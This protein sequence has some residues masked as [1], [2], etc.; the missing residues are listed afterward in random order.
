VD[1][2]LGTTRTLAPPDARSGDEGGMMARMN[3]GEFAQASGLTAKA[4]RLYDKLNLLTPAEIHPHTGYRY[5]DTS[6]LERAR[7][8]ASLR[9][10]GMPL[11]RIRTVAELPP[12]AGA[13]EVASYWRG[14]EADMAARKQLADSLVD[15]LSNKEFDMADTSG[16]LVLHSAAHTA[17]GLVRASNEDAVYAGTHL[18]AAAD[19]FGMQHS[20]HSAAAAAIAALEEFDTETT[21]ESVLATLAAAA[22]AARTSVHACDEAEPSGDQVGSTLTAMLRCD[23]PVALAHIGDSRA[24]LSRGGELHRLTDDHTYVQSLVD[25]GKLT[26]DEAA[27]HQQRKRLLRALHSGDTCEPD[28]HLRQAQ[29]G[30]RYLLC[31]DGLHAV[32]DDRRIRRTL[33]T[34]GDATEVVAELARMVDEAGA[35]DNVAH[36]VVD[37]ERA[38]DDPSRTRQVHGGAQ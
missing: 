23:A 27:L 30:D 1:L 2:A 32:L 28:L 26:P 4:L 29:P 10:L 21:P 3:I 12:Q 24:Y 20:N 17:N 34:D 9:G 18:F 5:Y 25:D 8:V 36:V 11:A 38:P 37:T 19:G 33:A 22:A 31:S 16:D 6:Q 15:H 13:T 35:P 7:L 14:V